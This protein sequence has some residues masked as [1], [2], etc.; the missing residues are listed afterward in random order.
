MKMK[1]VIAIAVLMSGLMA[2]AQQPLH[3]KD[4][5][6]IAKDANGAV[7]S[8]LM[9]DKEGH[10]VALGS[11]F[12]VSKDGRVV[13]NYHVIKSGTSAVIKLPDGASFAVDGVLVSD[14]DR[15]VAIIKVHG[16]D[17]R[18]LILGDCSDLTVNNAGTSLPQRSE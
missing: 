16:G 14:K 8:I 9:S 4:I 10:P 5:A 15:D 18:M 2:Q 13:T 6:A 12:L 1:T 3:Q 17:F 11:G 7:V